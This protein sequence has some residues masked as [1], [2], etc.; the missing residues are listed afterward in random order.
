MDHSQSLPFVE[1]AI[2]SKAQPGS[3]INERDRVVRDVVAR[4]FRR[5][6]LKVDF[7]HVTDNSS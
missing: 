4:V 5:M 3:A 1:A 7:Q 6:K 2:A